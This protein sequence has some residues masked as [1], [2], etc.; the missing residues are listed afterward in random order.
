MLRKLSLGIVL[1]AIT[2]GSAQEVKAQAF[3][4]GGTY[5]T[6]GLTGS[7]LINIDPTNQWSSNHS[8]RNSVNGGVT[9]QMEWGIHQY[10]G[11]GF[12]A[13][14]MGGR[15]GGGWYAPGPWGPGW[16]GGY[17]VLSVP[18]GMIANFH[19]YQ[20]I[21]DKTTRDIHGDKLDIYAGL[22]IGSGIG[23]VP[24]PGWVN[25]LFFVGPQ[26]GARYY[27]TPTIGL[28]GEVGYGKSFINGGVT[29]KL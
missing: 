21:E 19:F 5:L 18:V 22:N 1:A 2:I 4:K 26:V 28:G 25:A 15:F 23:F 11:L 3:E 14:L 10:V 12:T 13:G 27:V 20:L 6:L 7:H 16:G 17:G 8:W 24:S 9:V 29:F